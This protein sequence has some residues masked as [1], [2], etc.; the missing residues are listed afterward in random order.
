MTWTQEAA[1]SNPATQTIAESRAAL[2][3]LTAYNAAMQVKPL[4]ESALSLLKRHA[5]GEAVADDDPARRELLEA[6][7]LIRAHS[8]TRGWYYA[9]SREGWRL[10]SEPSPSESAAPRQ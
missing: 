7:L 3:R 1:G 6:G 8:F 5:S 9:P 2:R 10:V 4:S